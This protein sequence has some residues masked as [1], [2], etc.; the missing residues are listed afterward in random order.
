M[1]FAE[2]IDQDQAAQNVQSDLL[3]IPSACVVMPSRE[4]DMYDFQREYLHPSESA[5]F[6]YLVREVLTL[7]TSIPYHIIQ[8]F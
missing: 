7:W 2:S 4:K 6:L 1:V 8:I 3:S 5:D